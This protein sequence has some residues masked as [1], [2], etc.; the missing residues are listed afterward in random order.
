MPLSYLPSNPFPTAFTYAAVKP[1]G[2]VSKP[3]TEL[4]PH[5]YAALR[6][7]H[8][9][10]DEAIDYALANWEP[11]KVDTEAPK[12]GLDDESESRLT[13]GTT[14]VYWGQFNFGELE[15]D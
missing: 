13:G 14:K 4:N 11:V 15:T 10:C 3:V 5:T 6:D 1:E 9:C 7:Y 2:T 12:A 8:K